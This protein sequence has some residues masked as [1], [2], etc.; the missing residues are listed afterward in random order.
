MAID[1]SY[2]AHVDLD[3]AGLQRGQDRERAVACPEVVDGDVKAQIPQQL[4]D[5]VAIADIE[6]V[7]T[8]GNLQNHSVG[9]RAIT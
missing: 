5:L 6:D 9:M 1:I 2:D 8:L 4:G 7:A 3:V